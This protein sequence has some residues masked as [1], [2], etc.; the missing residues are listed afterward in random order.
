MEVGGG[1]GRWRWAV[2]VGGG[3]GRWRWAV[4]CSYVEGVGRRGASARLQRGGVLAYTSVDG[5]WPCVMVDSSVPACDG[6]E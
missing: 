6:R 2:E 3:G 5:C 1:G 4:S